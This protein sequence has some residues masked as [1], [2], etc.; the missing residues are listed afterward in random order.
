MNLIL[1]LAVLLAYF[2]TSMQHAYLIDP[3]AR[4]SAWLVDESF[5]ECCQEFDHNQMFCGGKVHQFDVNGGKCS[6]CGEAWDQPRKFDKGGEK[7]LGTIVKEY[8]TGSEID[9][10]VVI[11]ANHLGH[12][13]FRVCKVD[14]WDGD[15]TQECLDQTVLYLANTTLTEYKI[16]EDFSTVNLKIQ[17]PKD[18]RCEHCVL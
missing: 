16:E 17:L 4:S 14:G 9:V 10:T 6:I 7:Y 15:A 1:T 11:T 8:K 3:P 18:L 2:R 13:E 12:F 5:F